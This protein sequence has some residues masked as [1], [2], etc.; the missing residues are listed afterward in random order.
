MNTLELRD[1][2]SQYV[3]ECRSIVEICKQEQREM[4]DEEKT[5]FEELKSDIATNKE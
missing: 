3:K 1:A 2:I 5:K 4:T